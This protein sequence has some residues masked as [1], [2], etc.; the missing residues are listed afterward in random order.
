METKTKKKL[1]AAGASVAAVGAA[2]AL[3]AGTFSF[4]SDQATGAPQKVTTGTLE[5]S[6]YGSGVKTTDV[7][8]AKPG[9]TFETGDLHFKNTGSIEGLPRLGITGISSTQ[10]GK[11]VQIK[12][13]GV[14]DLS[15][16]SG[17][18]DDCANDWCTL[19]HVR[20]LTNGS[21]ALVKTPP[22][23]LAGTQSKGISYKLRI[24]PN[25]TLQNESGSF[26]FVGDLVQD[27]SSGDPTITH[28]PA[29]SAHIVS[30]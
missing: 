10:F 14:Y 23:G 24:R 2:I 26:K 18:K 9:A 27:D 16:K 6:F 4:F 3:T 21:G 8:D 22:H 12:F 15:G 17:S 29:P 28:F 7:T 25:A 13:D 5:L 20:N 19:N 30:P 11:D 1:G